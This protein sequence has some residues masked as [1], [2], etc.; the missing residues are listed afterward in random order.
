[1]VGPLLSSLVNRTWLSTWSQKHCH[2]GQYQAEFPEVNLQIVVFLS[3]EG[4]L[5]EKAGWELLK[6][7]KI[8]RLTLTIHS[9]IS[10][11]WLAEGFK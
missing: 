10:S 11:G 7:Q 2:K 1:M 3:Q 8:K 5:K 9:P 6:G 4:F